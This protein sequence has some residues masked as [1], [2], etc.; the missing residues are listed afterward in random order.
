MANVNVALEVKGLLD[1]PKSGVKAA[2]NSYT[3]TPVGEHGVKVIAKQ[4]EVSVLGMDN[5]SYLLQNGQ[6]IKFGRTG[7][8]CRMLIS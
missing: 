3:I 6:T 5:L 7:A 8:K 2:D 1:N 4:I